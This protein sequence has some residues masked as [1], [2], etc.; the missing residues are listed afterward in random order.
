MIS[1]LTFLTLLFISVPVGFCLCL[2]A[3]VFLY[4]DDNTI[5]YSSYPTQLFDGASNYGLLAIPLFI[6][7]GEIMNGGGITKRIISMTLAFIGSLKGGLAYVNLLAN[8]FMASI[9]GSASAQVAV[10]SRVMVP[11][12]EKQ[13]YDKGFAVGLTVYGGLLGPIIPPSIMFVLYSVLARLSVGDMLLSGIVPGLILTIAFI[14]II[15]LLGLFYPYPVSDKLS[16]KVRVKNILSGLPTLLIPIFIIGSIIT[17]IANPTEAAAIGVLISGVIGY[18]WTKDL[19]MDSIPGMLMRAGVYSAIILFLV[20]AAGVFSWV[21]TYGHVPQLVASWITTV[22]ETPVQFML[23]LVLMLMVIG[24]MIDGAPALIMVVPILLPIA[25]D[26]YGIDPYHF[27]IV[28][29]I[30][31]V[32][33]FMTPPVGLCLYVASAICN[34]S[35][36]RVFKATIPYFLASIVVILLLAVYPAMS[37]VFL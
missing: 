4:L 27:G 28:T 8:M 14:L 21:L 13:G 33:A 34:M 23:L 37:R 2:V 11:E 30:T 7:I 26:V 10:M 17:G 36:L 25:V 9:M 24:T 35:P 19:K 32:L 5:L 29:V 22:A 16:P 18:F 15:A 6:L 3:I 20:S 1:G 12:M 31:L